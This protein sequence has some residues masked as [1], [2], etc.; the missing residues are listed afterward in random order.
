M[1]NISLKQ[2]PASSVPTPA[3]N[4]VR[5]FSNIGDGGNLYFKNSSGSIETL[6]GSTYVPVTEVT[7][8]ELYNLYTT[9]SFVPGAYYL[10][11]N[12]ESIYKQPDF[13]LDGLIKPNL[14]T[15][16]KP[17]GW[18][19]QPILVMAISTTALAVDAY[20]PNISGGG[21]SGFH[22]DKIKY[23]F[24]SNQTEFGDFTKG[25]IIERIDEFG[26]R[27]DY[28]H[29]TILFKRY[30]NYERDTS[31]TG[32]ITDYNCVTGVVTGNSTLFSTE[33]SIGDIIILDSKADLGYDIGLKVKTIVSNTSMTVEVDSA[34][35]GG[36]PSAVSLTNS[37]TITPI[38]YTFTF[39]SFDFWIASATGEF[40]QYKEVYFGQSDDSD[41]DEYYTFASNSYDNKFSEYSYNYFIS[42]VNTL[43]LANNVFINASN[44]NRF[45]AV[46]ANNTLYS[47]Y[48]NLSNHTFFG[49]V[50][51][52]EFNNNLINS[53][54]YNNK[55]GSA[56]NNT[57]FA[58]FINNSL[59]TSLYFRFNNFKCNVNNTNFVTATHVY[60]PY[61]CDVFKNSLADVKLSYYNNSNSLT[62]DNITA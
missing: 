28:D 5:I 20:Q 6:G 8:T 49:N 42:H 43:I 54:F 10:I 12:F 23:D 57:F 56:I 26:N 2:V 38:S 58:D 44:N 11:T 40:N 37:T 16:G 52:G 46:S 45:D 29:R 39:K 48:G 15:R 31:L 3:A 51:S 13:Y 36:V 18:G 1:S 53:P 55:I 4:Y 41:Y 21:Y 14:V 50:S 25:R 30:Q 19:Y 22:K 34:Y 9:S 24:L 47:A 33:L 61:N 17:P 62:V 32:T 27:T 7:Y 60:L 59:N 35:T